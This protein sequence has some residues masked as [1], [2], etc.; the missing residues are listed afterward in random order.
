MAPSSTSVDLSVLRNGIPTELPTHPGVHPD[1][2]VPRAPRRNI[3]GLSK[4]ELVLAVQNALRYFP[5]PM[6]ATLA[7]EFAQELKDEGHIYMH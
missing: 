2:S 1:P 5:E 3:D 7:P 4:D 6:H